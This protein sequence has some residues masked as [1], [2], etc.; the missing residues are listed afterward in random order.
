M[1]RALETRCEKFTLNYGENHMKFFFF[2]FA[3]FIC[4]N[5]SVYLHSITMPL[6]NAFSS[7]WIIS[8]RL[9]PWSNAWRKSTMTLR[10]P[11]STPPLILTSVCVCV[12]VNFITVPDNIRRIFHCFCF[13]R[14]ARSL[15]ADPTVITRF[16]FEWR[17]RAASK[18]RPRVDKITPQRKT[19]VWP[20]LT[21]P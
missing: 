21:G 17:Q 7:P 14:A 9:S 20:A 15:A 18:S 11:S 3:V 12:C 1:A 2:F 10:L 5:S 8:Y 19:R 4:R 6:W 16:L 13:T